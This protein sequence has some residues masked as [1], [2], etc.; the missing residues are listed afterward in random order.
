MKKEEVTKI[1]YSIECPIC[2]KTIKGTAAS[3][4]DWN[5]KKHIEF[6]HNQKSKE[7]DKK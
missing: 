7:E 5:L 4:V 2:K 1:V 3:Q 6:K